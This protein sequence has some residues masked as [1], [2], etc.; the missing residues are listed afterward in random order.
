MCFE[1]LYLWLCQPCAEEEEEEEV[2]LSIIAEEEE[3]EHIA[4][5]TNDQGE[6]ITCDDVQSDAGSAV[7]DFTESNAGLLNVGFCFSSSSH[8]IEALY[9]VSIQSES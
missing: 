9:S 5:Q 8:I 6:G 2:N 4:E 1:C 7:S 3:E